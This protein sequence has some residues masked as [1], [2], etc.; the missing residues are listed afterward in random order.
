MA[1]EGLA[2]GPLDRRVGAEIDVFRRV[3]RRVALHGVRVTRVPGIP[4]ADI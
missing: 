2:V 4:R 1:V 3:E